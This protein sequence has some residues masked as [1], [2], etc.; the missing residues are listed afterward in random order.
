MNYYKFVSNHID[1]ISKL[2]EEIRKNNYYTKIKNSD[3]DVLLFNR[4]KSFVEEF[5]NDKKSIYLAGKTSSGK[6]TFLNYII[7][8]DF[9]K[10]SII[11]ESLRTETRV[12]LKLQNSNKKEAFVKYNDENET[13]KKYDISTEDQIKEF[14]AIIRK[15]KRKSYDP[16]MDINEVN[17]YL[18]LKYFEEY[19]IYDTPGLGS[20]SDETD[21]NV[22]KQ[23]I[24]HSFA[25]WLLNGGELEMND[26]IRVIDEKKDILKKFINE[27]L[28]F[29]SNCYDLLKEKEAQYK[30]DS[31]NSMSIEDYSKAKLEN[32]LKEKGI[33]YSQIVFTSLKGEY[34]KEITEN[35][36]K[37]IEEQIDG[38]YRKISIHIL[39]GVII[40][41]N[42]LMEYFVE[43]NEQ[44]ATELKKEKTGIMEDENSINEKKRSIK[45]KLLNVENI[46]NFEKI[47]REFDNEIESCNNKSKVKEFNKCAE[48]FIKKINSYD[49]N[50]ENYA[51]LNE[52]EK[53]NIRK[54]I[55]FTE[56]NF[57]ETRAGVK[58]YLTLFN[59]PIGNIILNPNKKDLTSKYNNFLCELKLVKMNIQKSLEIM[60]VSKE[61]AIDL[62]FRDEL[63][64]LSTK[65]SEIDSEIKENYD[66]GKIVSNM[67][68]KNNGFKDKCFMKLKEEL[69]NWES[70]NYPPWK[71]DKLEKFFELWKITKDL[72]EFK[73][74]HYGKI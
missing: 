55:S 37:K 20:G 15:N 2:L 45:S 67:K 30:T 29:I 54:D 6:S 39:Q 71:G 43:L 24:G 31:N 9:K 41:V 16:L 60:N 63:L 62:E 1:E 33:G 17:L 56:Y 34:C 36:I 51:D 14:H 10:I 52:S 70:R 27:Q 64:K 21:D 73:E 68:I 49:I 5:K 13:I 48:D 35:S 26:A 42:S 46:I 40:R 19:I 4:F 58:K 23:F 72:N 25:L 8:Q 57:N 18:P 65:K 74:Y 61:D 12:I 28:I 69:E 44:K 66:F 59:T 47:K 32:Y 11:P 53:V 38:N 22:I 3:D 7:K 50:I